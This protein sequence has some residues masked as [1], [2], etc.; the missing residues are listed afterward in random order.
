MKKILLSVFAVLILASCSNYYGKDDFHGSYER[1]SEKKVY[2]EKIVEV[3]L[4][5]HMRLL[6]RAL[7]ID[8]LGGSG[9]KLS[10]F[11]TDGKSIWDDGA[12]WKARDAIET[13]SGAAIEK[14]EEDSTWVVKRDA[15]ALYWVRSVPT[16]SEVILRMR[17]TPEDAPNH[18]WD[19][20]VVNFVRT[21]NLGYKAFVHTEEPAV[22]RVASS[23]DSWGTCKGEFWM[24]VTRDN[25]EIDHAVLSY[26]GG[27]ST[28]YFF[29]NL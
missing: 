7:L 18:E 29:N 20:S 8:D 13:L 14:A 6:E 22:F 10:S 12:C 26:N 3:Y 27:P 1:E 4:T 25:E 21:E 24:T 15:E 17:P 23:E 2:L 16:R 5:D 9:R 28:A 19:L 11:E